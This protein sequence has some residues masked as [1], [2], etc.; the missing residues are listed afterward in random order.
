[1]RRYNNYTMCFLAFLLLIIGAG[2]SDPD[3]TSN[4]GLTPPTVIS[5]EPPDGSAGVCPSTIVTATFSKAMNP[6][7][8][9]DTTFL[10]AGPGTTAVA[11]VVTY[12]APSNTATF[13][14]SSSLAIP[15]VTY[16]ATITTGAQ[17]KPCRYVCRPSSERVGRTV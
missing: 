10:L 7:T 1:M 11:G 17:G 5:V 15:T 3:K 12:D 9:N 6:A 2:C 13:T 8:I 4:P 14:P 16:T